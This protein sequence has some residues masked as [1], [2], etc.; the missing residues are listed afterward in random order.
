MAAGS[1]RA[2]DPAPAPA[3]PKD[4]QLYS[5]CRGTTR[6]LKPKSATDP[7]YAA[8]AEKVNEIWANSVKIIAEHQ[9]ARDNGGPRNVQVNFSKGYISFEDAN[10]KE[11][12]L[13]M[14]TNLNNPGKTQELQDLMHEISHTGKELSSYFNRPQNNPEDS[15]A[16]TSSPEWDAIRP[17]SHEEFRAKGQE[18]ALIARISARPAGGANAVNEARQRIENT[19]QFMTKLAEKLKTDRET[20]EEALGNMDD[21]AN[22]L[23]T[24]HPGRLELQ[25][26]IAR[27]RQLE[28]ML[29]SIDTKGT[30]DAIYWAVG[31]GGEIYDVDP[32]PV[33]MLADKAA[34]ISQEMQIALRCP[35]S[36]ED[37]RGTVE[38]R[39]GLNK[40]PGYILNDSA[41]TPYL[42]AYAQDAGNLV[43]SGD[44][45]EHFIVHC[46]TRMATEGGDLDAAL[47][48]LG[49]SFTDAEK[50][51][52]TS[53]A[54]DAIR[55]INAAPA[56]LPEALV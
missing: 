53:A 56:P 43:Y 21:P 40:P 15:F 2:L 29:A 24:N 20:L 52:I 13:N 30:R 22:F 27:L 10:G 47:D 7:K 37:P 18:R 32:N 39:L 16:T 41:T 11:Y 9:I 5:W 28:E 17:R 55:E 42:T 25:N 54:K 33:Q 34:Q 38:K 26:K 51:R 31:A 36:P 50:N 19:S 14:H 23:P 45:I 48:A 12:R 1:I 6:E 8:T 44:S 49:I 4:C 46:A 35:I 3:T